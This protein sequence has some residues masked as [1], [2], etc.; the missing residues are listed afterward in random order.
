MGEILDFT[1]AEKVPAFTIQAHKDHVGVWCVSVPEFYDTKMPVHEMFREIADA[2][3][4]IAGGMIHN[5]E[6]L[7]PTSRG[8]IVTNISLYEDGYIEL[9]TAEL[10]TPEKK[11][12]L[13]QA[14]ENVRDGI[15][16][17]KLDK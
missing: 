7:E 12:W 17:G 1:P 2:L 8:C 14:I 5:A 6:A 4:G 13:I 16:A 10:D 3:I 11:A 15:I 9:K